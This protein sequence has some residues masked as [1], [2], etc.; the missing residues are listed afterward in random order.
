[1]AHAHEDNARSLIVVGASARA[2]AYSAWRAGFA[3][4]ACD[5]FGDADLR[6]LCPWSLAR[7]YPAGLVATASQQPP[8]AWLFTGGLENHPSIVDDIARE[9]PLLGNA[10]DILR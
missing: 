10:G 6:R 1:M 7:D 9:R 5:L 4:L 2:A 3:P 8:C